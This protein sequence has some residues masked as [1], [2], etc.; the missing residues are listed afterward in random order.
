MKKSQVGGIL[1]NIG[2]WS[3]LLSRNQKSP[4]QRMPPQLC[5]IKIRTGYLLVNFYLIAIDANV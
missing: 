1:G 5:Q 4:E 2:I 3:I